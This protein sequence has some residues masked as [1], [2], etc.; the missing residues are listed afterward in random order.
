MV[1]KFKLYEVSFCFT[2]HKQATL[3]QWEKQT[4]NN[5]Q[6]MGPLIL[7]PVSSVTQPDLILRRGNV[8]SLD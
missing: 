2:L 8:G 4:K 3:V 5:P 1:P 6:T 7:F